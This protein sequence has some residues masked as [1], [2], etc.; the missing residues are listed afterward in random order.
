MVYCVQGNILTGEPVVA[1]ALDA[2]IH[3]NLDLPGRLMAGME[4]AR[5]M[6][7][8]GRCSCLSG[9]ATSCGS[10]PASFVRTA[11]CGYFIV[12]RAGDSDL[13]AIP[14][15]STCNTPPA[16]ADLNGDGLLE[17][18][19]PDSSLALATSFRVFANTAP[20]GA[21]MPAFNAGTSYP[22]VVSP[23]VVATGDLTGDG[24]ADVVVG[25]GSTVTG[26]AGA[27]TLYRARADGGLEARTDIATPRRVLGAVIADVDGRLG[28]DL[29]YSTTSQLF[30]A[31]N[32]GNGTFAAPVVLGNYTNG[33]GLVVTDVTGD[34]FADIVIGAGF[35]GIRWLSGRG[36]G[37]FAA[38][39]T[40]PLVATGRGVV[41]HDFNGD[42]RKDMAALTASSVNSIVMAMN[43]GTGFTASTTYSLG[44]VGNSL[45]L[46]DI[47]RDGR[48][49]LACIDSLFRVVTLFANATG[50]FAVTQRIA[51]GTAAGA[52]LL[53]DLNNDGLPE[54]VAC[55]GPTLV[56][57]NSRGTFMNP[58]GFAA[59]KYFMDINIANQSA[60]AVDPVFQMQDAFN[61]LRASVVGVPDATRSRVTLSTGTKNPVL[62][63]PVQ[64][65]VELRD[66]RGIAAA[67]PLQSLVVSR[68]GPGPFAT[69]LGTPVSLGNGRFRIDVA[70]VAPGTDRY[71]IVANDGNGP[72]TLMPSP[73][74]TVVVPGASVKAP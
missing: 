32:T 4:A 60:T 58:A 47:D 11:N 6:G 1:A 54:A 5:S 21:L 37:T 73:A 8:D 40:I 30:V 49:D 10:P 62:G 41:V 16:A 44:S 15:A 18:V 42:G 55:T 51:A 68:Q 35:A 52:M 70:T 69:T 36:D 19:V 72:V 39:T 59:G 50:G 71:L 57:G 66:Y 61:A 53:S 34:G 31:L 65:V 63:K 23:A 12:S 26:A 28:S 7:G 38:M 74:V 13:G 45:C 67:G 17:L 33:A 20:I 3:T 9:G 43:T 29:I 22:C 27:L 24:R 48:Q 14:L 25:G 56:L 2:I 64:M 46:A